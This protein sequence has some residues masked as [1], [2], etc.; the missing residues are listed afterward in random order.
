MKQEETFLEYIQ[1]K[2]VPGAG[3]ILRRSIW[4]MRRRR[5]R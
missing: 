4:I 5:A 2:A 3:Y 1:E